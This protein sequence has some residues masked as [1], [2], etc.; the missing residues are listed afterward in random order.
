[1]AVWQASTFFGRQCRLTTVLPRNGELA[2][3]INAVFGSSCLKY[4]NRRAEYIQNWWNAVDWNIA[5]RA[6]SGDAAAGGD[7]N[8]IDSTWDW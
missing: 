8:D 4:Q 3:A 7:V 6:L 2:D 1:M 5:K